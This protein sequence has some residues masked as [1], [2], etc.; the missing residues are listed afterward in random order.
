[1][2]IATSGAVPVPV[3][4]MGAGLAMPETVIVTLAVRAF[5][6]VGSN[7]TLSTQLEFGA[8]CPALEVGQ[9]V[10][11]LAKAKSPASA[12]VNAM[13]VTLRGAPPLLVSVTVCAAL[14]VPMA[15]LVNVKLVGEGVAV[16]GV[17][18]VPD[19]LM[20]CVVG[21]ASSV[22]VMVALYAI[23]VAGVNVTAIVQVLFG[24]VK[25]TVE[26][27]VQVVPDPGTMAKSAG[28]VPPSAT[29]LMSSVAVPVLVTVIV[30][31]ALVVVWIWF[32]NV[33]VLELSETAGCVPVPVSVN[34]CGLP[35]ALSA[36]E[37]VAV[38]APVAL[39][40]NVTAIVHVPLAATDPTPTQF[41]PLE[42]ATSAKSPAFVPV[43]VTLVI[44][45][46]DV[47]LFVSTELICAAVVPTR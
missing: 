6:A 33:T 8:T 7:V 18:P 29:V 38:R 17:T 28:F 43:I 45:S 46:E 4:V 16:G 24:A 30:C 15:W 21:E 25:P 3:S 19:R 23:A 35:V 34:V 22:S 31:A 40:V 39:G 41:V 32:A 37:T 1:M 20:T 12:P 47:A 42:G 36:T 9:V 2:V 27:F 14:V 26:L 10:A 11:G 5:K 13:L 44:E